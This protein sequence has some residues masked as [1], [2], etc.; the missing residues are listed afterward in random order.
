MTEADKK[1][2]LATSGNV[3]VNVD[4]VMQQ[5]NH[6]ASNEGSG[7]CKQWKLEGNRSTLKIKIMAVDKIS[8]LVNV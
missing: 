7:A 4:N 5:T 8:L 2:K 3:P 6:R 1:K